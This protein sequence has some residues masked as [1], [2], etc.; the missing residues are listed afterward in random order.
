M[1]KKGNNLLF[2]NGQQYGTFNDTVASRRAEG[3]L[4]S[5]CFITISPDGLA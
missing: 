1:P 2:E 4:A 3:F 5:H